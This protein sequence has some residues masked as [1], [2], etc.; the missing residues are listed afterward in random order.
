MTSGEVVYSLCDYAKVFIRKYK[1]PKL[2]QNVI[3]TVTVDFINYFAAMHCEMDLAMMTKDLKDG[4]K[5]SEEKT[6][7]DKFVIL[8]TLNFWKNQYESK[9]KSNQ[10]EISQIVEEFIKYYMAA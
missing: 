4:K 5:I 2:D 3:D 7:L 10:A 9:A 6:V 1:N 8:P